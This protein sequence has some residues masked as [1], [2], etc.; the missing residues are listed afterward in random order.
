MVIIF[1]RVKDKEAANNQQKLDTMFRG[2]PLR[3]KL[4][5]KRLDD[6]MDVSCLNDMWTEPQA[7]FESLK[8][9]L[10]G[11]YSVRLDAGHRIVF[12]PYHDPIPSKADGGIDLEQ[13]TT[14]QII[15]LAED[16]HARKSRK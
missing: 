2:N 10:R 9:N 8:G 6:L 12:K 11:C 7:A 1:S 16:Y 3:A 15:H 5:R 13:V 14:I 4:V